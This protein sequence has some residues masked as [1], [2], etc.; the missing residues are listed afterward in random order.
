MS[1]SIPSRLNVLQSRKIEQILTCS[2]SPT[3]LI[4]VRQARTC[5][6][7]RISLH[8]RPKS[9]S[10][11]I[12]NG[13]NSTLIYA[14]HVHHLRLSLAHIYSP[15]RLFAGQKITGGKF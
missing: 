5:M 4:D 2:P 10:G 6:C 3:S 9:C 15:I 1:E 8:Q 14:E 11:R 7:I 12:E 13:I